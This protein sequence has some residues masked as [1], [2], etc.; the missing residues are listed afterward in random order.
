MVVK[1]ADMRVPF[2]GTL[3]QETWGGAQE[4]V[5]LT[6]AWLTDKQVG[7]GDCLSSTALGHHNGC[8][9]FGS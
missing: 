9:L 8:H 2:P 7:K 6:S 5:F 4:H 3:L 1:N